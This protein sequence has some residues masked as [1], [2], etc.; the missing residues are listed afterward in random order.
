MSNPKWTEE[1]WIAFIV[2]VVTPTVGIV[3][4]KT[5]IEREKK[6]LE[7]TTAAMP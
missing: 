4:Y 1:D 7:S 6:E 3:L 2:A 5:R